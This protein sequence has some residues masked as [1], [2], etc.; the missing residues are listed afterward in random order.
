MWQEISGDIAVAQDS[1][2]EQVGYKLVGDNIVKARYMR[3]EQHCN[4]SL[5]YFNSFAVLNRIDFSSF[6][7]SLPLSCVNHPHELALSLLPSKE[8][9][10]I[11]KSH[12]A[13]LISRILYSHM[14]F[15]KVSF[16]GCVE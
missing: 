3:V 16:D 13:T 7:T 12:F 6:P 10:K 14:E 15:F 4:K 5:H 11:M 8:H 1:M 2:P 9:D